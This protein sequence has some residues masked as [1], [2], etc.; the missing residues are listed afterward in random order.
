MVSR[1]TS[2]VARDASLIAVSTAA[3]VIAYWPSPGPRQLVVLRQVSANHPIASERLPSAN[4]QG[5]QTSRGVFSLPIDDPRLQVLEQKL[6]QWG[7]PEPDSTVAIARWRL[8]LAEFY[9]AAAK[10]TGPSAPRVVDWSQRAEEA[11]QLI[12]RLEQNRE[13]RRR[14]TGAAPI[15]LGAVFEPGMPPAAFLV[16]LAAAA[17][18]FLGAW[19]WAAR[20]PPVGFQRTRSSQLSSAPLT[21][22]D[23]SPSFGVDGGVSGERVLALR[24]PPEWIRIHQPVGVTLRRIC[25]ALIVA[26]A[27]A[28]SFLGDPLQ[29]SVG[30]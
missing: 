30:L 27:I 6:T 16:A 23:D 20:F 11:K 4:E 5:V 24:I 9:A 1:P 3:I 12:E 22:P 14:Q 2:T 21:Q 18:A 28:S 13:E 8:E 17:V 25:F 15:E 26:I 10:G 19:L 29:L 7:T